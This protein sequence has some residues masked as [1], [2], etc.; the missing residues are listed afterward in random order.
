MK[1]KDLDR[2]LKPHS[3]AKVRL[4]GEYLKRYLN[5]IAN[6]GYTERI[7]IYDLFCGEGIYG[8]DKEGSPM[9][10]LRAI[11]D[12]YFANVAKVKKLPSIDCQF[13]DI[14]SEKVNKVKKSIEDKSLYYPQYGKIDF[15]VGDYKDEIKKISGYFK[16]STKQ[17]GF[18]FIDPHGYGNIR[19]S[20]I[21]SLLNGGNTEVLLFLPTQFMYRFDSKGTPIA[22]VDFID[23]LAVDYK[24][25]KNPNSS[26]KY[27]R[28]LKEAFEAY[29]GN[30]F[31][32][33]NFTIEKDPQ[34]VFCLFFFSSHI[35]GFEKM[36]E[37]KWEI[38]TEQGKG[39]SY[40][41]TSLNIFNSIKTN[42]LEEKLIQ[43]L[44]D[45]MRSNADVYEF[46][47]RNGFL[48][49]HTNEVF[50]NLQNSGKLL[51]EHSNGEKAR[52]GAFYIT[53]KQHKEEPNKV[54]FKLI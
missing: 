28:Q 24:N 14:N 13:N 3:V 20:D 46:T 50:Y 9:I 2:D 30:K 44:R 22:L 15:T 34:T 1:R 26:W 41:D 52:K 33:D 10:I 29:F 23:E 16:S 53:Y 11:K 45:N 25:W 47:L 17:K 37:A 48:P 36:L 7:K 32:V 27:I 18:I 6:D 38:D 51:V 12:L 42:P 54:Q 8:N 21:K 4:L 43:Y 40:T 35:K 5:I 19:A 39:W 31:F 49:K